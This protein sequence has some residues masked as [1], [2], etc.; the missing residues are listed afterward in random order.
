[1]VDERF[2]SGLQFGVFT[3]EAKRKEVIKKCGLVRKC[4]RQGECSAKEAKGASSS[5]MLICG[6]DRQSNCCHRRAEDAQGNQK[7][8]LAFWACGRPSVEPTI[9][10]S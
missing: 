10:K 3:P 9:S 6:S 2:L 1:M 8:P 4:R 7:G 5:P